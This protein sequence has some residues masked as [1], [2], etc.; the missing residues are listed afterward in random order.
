M[1][2]SFIEAFL[3]CPVAS[4]KMKHSIYH[5]AESIKTIKVCSKEDG[6]ACLQI[7]VYIC[8]HKHIPCLTRRLCMYMPLVFI[9]L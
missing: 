7:F 2:L 9:N 6:E 8:N 1:A 5:V 4:Y 3:I